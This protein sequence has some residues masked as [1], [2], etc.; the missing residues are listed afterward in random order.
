MKRYRDCFEIE[1][2]PLPL[3]LKNFQVSLVLAELK[4]TN[5]S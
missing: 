4:R 1:Y 5:C 2:L 3:F